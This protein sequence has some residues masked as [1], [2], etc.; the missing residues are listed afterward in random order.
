MEKGQKTNRT[1]NQ[2]EAA[3]ETVFKTNGFEVVK[4]RQWEKNPGIFEEELLLKNVPFKTV[5]GHNGNTEFLVKSEKYNLHQL[6]Q[7][8]SYHF[9]YKTLYEQLLEYCIFLKQ[10]LRS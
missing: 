1:G 2:L 7:F 3:V 8:F 5:Y 4:Y 10:A 6:H 9:F